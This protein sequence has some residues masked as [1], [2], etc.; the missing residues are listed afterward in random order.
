MARKPPIPTVS[1]KVSKKNKAGDIGITSTGKY[2]V[3]T[4]QGWSGNYESQT[5]AIDFMKTLHGNI[6][7][8]IVEARKRGGTVSRTKGGTMTKSEKETIRKNRQ[9]ILRKTRAKHA[10]DNP[11]GRRR[12]SNLLGENTGMGFT[13]KT[14]RSKNKR[15]GKIMKGYKAGGKV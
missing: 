5:G 6:G 7:P 10:K 12:L 8:R 11:A 4:G 9:S 13:P 1:S 15:G 14:T 2:K 3:W